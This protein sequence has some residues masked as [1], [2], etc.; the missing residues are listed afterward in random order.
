MFSAFYS[1]LSYVLLVLSLILAVGSAI[2]LIFFRQ[3]ITG[4]GGFGDIVAS[5][6]IVVGTAI[7]LITLIALLFGNST[8]AGFLGLCAVFGFFIY[9]PDSRVYAI[10]LF[11]INLLIYFS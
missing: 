4:G 7:F 5:L 8:I 6:Y 1:G 3:E 10:I 2:A 9:A 11:I